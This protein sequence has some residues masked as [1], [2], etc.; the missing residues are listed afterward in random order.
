LKLSDNQLVSLPSTIGYL[1]KLATLT[2]NNNKII[3]LPPEIGQIKSLVNLDLA[4]NPI[5]VLPAELG[6]LRYLRKLCL[7]GCPLVKKF[8]HEHV[9]SPPSLFE[10]AARTIVRQQLPIVNSLQQDIKCY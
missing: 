4:D 7:D 5:K 1:T 10:L 6:R 3:E 9:H 8:V 2:L